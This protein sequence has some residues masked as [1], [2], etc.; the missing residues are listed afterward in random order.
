MCSKNIEKFQSYAP[1]NFGRHL[2]SDRKACFSTI[3]KIAAILKICVKNFLI[4][5]N[6]EGLQVRLEN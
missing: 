5:S 4:F 1:L 2:E 3:L 6:S